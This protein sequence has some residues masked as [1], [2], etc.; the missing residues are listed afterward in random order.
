MKVKAIFNNNSM[1]VCL[2]RGVSDRTIKAA[3]RDGAR[4]LA[5]VSA[6]SGAGTDCGACRG[7]IRDMIED[8]EDEAS[9]CSAHR[10]LPV[11]Q[12]LGGVRRVAM[13]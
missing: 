5:Q 2:C 6:C 7:V 1:Y 9:P 10:S 13:D 3:I 8:H 11:L 12:P 4:S